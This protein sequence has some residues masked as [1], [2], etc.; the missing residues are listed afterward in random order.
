MLKVYLS[1]DHV[2]PATGKTVAITISKNGGAFGNPNAGATNA[3]EVSSGWYKVTLDTTDTGTAGDLVVRG[4]SATCDDSERVLAVVKATNGGLTA[5]PDAVAGA[6]DGLLINGTNSGNITLAA[7]AINGDFSAATGHFSSL[8]ISNTL[9]VAAVAFGVF[10]VASG[11]ITTTIHGTVD[12]NVIK[13]NNA[14][15]TGAGTAGDPWGPA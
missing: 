9:I 6:S 2:S 14:T 3:T 1:S 8:S 4:T 15:I 12:A 13:V 5:L 7:L 10:D 11:D